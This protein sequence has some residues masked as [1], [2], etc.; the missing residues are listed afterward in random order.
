ML[1]NFSDIWSEHVKI[2]H[3]S[4]V[5]NLIDC[6]NLRSRPWG[7]K[8]VA[9]FVTRN[10][11][12]LSN[13]EVQAI[14]DSIVDFERCCNQYG[15]G[16]RAAAT[17]KFTAV[18]N[19]D[20]FARMTGQRWGAYELCMRAKYQICP[21]CQQSFAMTVLRSDGSRCF[22]PTLDHYYSKATYSFLSVS[23]NNLVPSCYA[24]N[25]SLKG[26]IDFFGKSHLHP[27]EDEEVLGFR[28]DMDAYLK[29]RTE[30]VGRWSVKIT[31]D[32]KCSKQSNVIKTFALEER[33]NQLDALTKR[34]AEKAYQYFFQGR[35]RY[36][37]LMAGAA[38][39][40]AIVVELDFDESN[41]RNE[42]FGKLKLDV[43]AQIKAAALAAG[44]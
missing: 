2:I 4:F 23:L 16:W 36:N 41:Y 43:V 34:F 27:F 44:A 26:S 24:C 11:S 32:R 30:G 40:P 33:Y 28:L 25:S 14:R 15:K 39:L 5:N 20:R 35:G 38:P 17:K 19:Y 37:E 21:Y 10:R 6:E 3:G 22:R 18:L 29:G 42:M 31:H 1:V 13:G 8:S 7:R 9:D 12:A